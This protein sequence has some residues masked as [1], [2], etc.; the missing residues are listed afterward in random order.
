[1]ADGMDVNNPKTPRPTFI[2]RVSTPVAIFI[3]PTRRPVLAYPFI[4]SAGLNEF[5]NLSSQPTVI[6]R[7]D[8][9]ANS[10][11][12]SSLPYYVIAESPSSLAAGDAQSNAAWAGYPGNNVRGVVGLHAKI[13]LADIADGTSNTYMVGEK[14]LNP[15]A[16]TTGGSLGDNQ[17]WDSGWTADNIRICGLIGSALTADFQPLQDTPGFD[18]SINFGSAHPSGF[19]MAFCDGSVTSVNYNI[20]LEINRRLGDRADGLPIDAK[21]L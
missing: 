17:G 3:C 7:S 11:E 16:Y 5:V 21:K 14:N 6:G 9:A 4:V 2:R 10:G 1:M 18:P 12:S 15:D 13:K 19:G 8:Y 20:D